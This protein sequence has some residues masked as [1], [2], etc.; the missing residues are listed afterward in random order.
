MTFS[1]ILI[2][3]WDGV[4]LKSAW[5]EKPRDI[6][7]VYLVPENTPNSQVKYR[8]LTVT[9]SKEGSKSSNVERN[10]GLNQKTYVDPDSLIWLNYLGW[11]C[12]EI[13]PNSSTS[14]PHR[15]I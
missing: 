2:G 1:S 7:Q 12:T 6:G 14:C 10:T 11:L 8:Y 13:L 4:I 9:V 3:G 15:N 5:S